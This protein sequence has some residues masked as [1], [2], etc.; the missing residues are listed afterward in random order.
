MEEGDPAGGKAPAAA[1][2][3]IE[4]SISGKRWRDRLDDPPRGSASEAGERAALALAQRHGLP[5]IVGRVLAA[6]G[7][8]PDDVDDFLN[9]TLK[10]L[11]PDPFH[12]RGM[13]AAV[14]RL[15]RAI[16]AGE[17]VAVFGD[18]DV[19]GA[20]AAALLVRFF[21][22][23]GRSTPVYI[24]DRIAEGYGPNL[25]AFEKLKAGGASVVITVDCGTT[26]FEAL[27]GAAEA[28]IEVIV[29]D[30]HV[31]EP[32]LPP[33][34]AVVNPNRLDK[35]SPHG[36]LAAVGVTFLLV[37]ALNKALR[38][39]CWYGEGHA[40]PDLRAWLDLVAV[41]T[42]CDVVPLT[43]VNRGLVAQGLKVLARRGNAGLA[44]LAD[45]AR[46]NERPET[47]HAGFI[48]GPRINAGGRIGEPGLGV[49]LL[50]AD[51]P[52]EAR[53]IAE[54]LDG[55][56]TERQ[57]IEAEVLE[58]AAALAE[59]QASRPVVLVAGEGWHPGVIGIVAGRLRERFDRPCC[60]VALSDGIGKG[61]GRSVPGVGLGPAVVAA[62]QAGHL[63]NGG[64]HIMAAGF[65]VARDRIEA[66]REFITDH[67]VHQLGG[68]DLVAQ[69]G[70]DGVLTPAGAT[71][72]LVAL[73][74]SAGPFGAGN[75]RPRFAFP[76]VRVIRA[77]VVGGDH[78]RCVVQGLDGGPRI[79][80]IA[81][82]AADSPLGRA[83]L[84][85][86]SAPL[87]LAGHIRAD[88][89]NGGVAAQLI[90]E[91][92]AYPSALYEQVRGPYEI[93]TDS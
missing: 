24:P 64:G 32:R 41:G 56:N 88:R 50:T 30:H 77:D 5:E 58:Q 92:A 84:T 39:A 53:L 42:V 54:R 37:V 35:T 18:Y 73:L 44:A 10:A 34:C 31:A 51:D 33:A 78:V 7:V 67:V 28:G 12:L 4:R 29:I 3:G 1:F 11:L 82:R 27:A 76:G 60:V 81:F 63:I 74:E 80:A 57:R 85:G 47:Y 72:D 23:L 48:L 87:H 55:Y 8:A 2:L 14:E 71:V 19:D 90:I 17:T 49:R 46:L 13:A 21:A 36:Q 69:M 16:N 40:E 59:P 9:P 93:A 75:A 66:F 89:W 83:L 52:G 22:A 79:A 43:G 68:N 45:V 62:H 91:D 38:E 26:A 65:T 6:R 61:S 70:F 86:R 20:T 25:P 15:V